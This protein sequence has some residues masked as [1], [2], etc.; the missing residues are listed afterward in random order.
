MQN[1][2]TPVFIASQNGLTETLALLLANKADPNA[3]S[4]VHQFKI[5]K[6]F[7]LID[8]ELHDFNIPFYNQGV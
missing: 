1:G 7:Q 5:F 8:N 4:K 6:C 2:S 3:A